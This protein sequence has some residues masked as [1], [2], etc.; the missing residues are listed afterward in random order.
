MAAASRRPRDP[1]C[2]AVAL[3]ATTL[4]LLDVLPLVA[5]NQLDESCKG[6][7]FGSLATS[8][9]STGRRAT[10]G[11]FRSTDDALFAPQ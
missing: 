1:L 9:S 4:V 6:S 3:V 5:C 11:V 8:G 10:G 7:H 2:G